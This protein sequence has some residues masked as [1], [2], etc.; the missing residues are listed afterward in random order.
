MKKLLNVY[1][2]KGLT[3]LQTIDLVRKKYP[4]YND[5]KIGYAG[6]LD[7][8]AHGVLLLMV[9]EETTKE[10]DLYLNLSKE[11]EFEVVFGVSTD[12]YDTLGLLQ[13]NKPVIARP[14]SG[15]VEDPFG[16]ISSIKR[17]PRSLSVARNDIE[18]F[19]KSKLGKQTQ[20]YPPFSSKTIQGKPLFWWAKNNKLAKIEIPKRK[21]EITDFKLLKLD[22]IATAELKVEIMK[23]IDSV[24]GDFRQKE[25]KKTWE[26][27]FKKNNNQT[28][29]IAQFNISCSSG[30]YIRS[31]TNEL[32][33]QLGTGAITLDILRTKV[34]D[35]ELSQSL[36]L[37]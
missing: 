10:K 22:T 12:T 35:A 13:K 7:P 31:L 23:Q 25:I 18:K 19:I 5:E 21:I 28:F 2:P 36:A 6:R 37:T 33:E 8:L 3:P 9:G 4:E 24:D 14:Q 26:E 16:T 29:Q 32:G 11:Y 17:L 30:T 27:F 1:K 15:E 34:G 20:L